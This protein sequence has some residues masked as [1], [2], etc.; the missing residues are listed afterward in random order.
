MTSE[1]RHAVQVAEWKVNEV[2]ELVERIKKSRVVGVVGLRELPASDIQRIRGVLRSQAEI[3][4]VRNNI[5]K[6]AIE[7]C[8][9]E[10]HPLA[11]GIEDQSALIFTDTNPFQLKKILDREKRPMLMKAGGVAPKEI[12]IEAGETSFSPGPMVGKLQSA[13]I[14][15]AI[16]GGKVIINQRTV[17]AKQGDVVSQKQ[18]EIMQIMEIFPKDVGLELRAVYEDGLVFREKDLA[19]DVSAILGDLC[20]ASARALAFAVEIG[21]A[22]PSTIAPLLTKAQAGAR[23][24]VVE[25]AIPVPGM[26]ELLLAKASANASAVASLVEGPKTRSKPAAAAVAEEPKEEEKKESEE[27]TAAG[28]GSL[29]G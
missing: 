29:F 24:L 19:I 14:P 18:A 12:A 4:V 3:K 27:D 15:A 23:N 26:A 11:E 9:P 22:S 20:T 17:L 16:K 5:A 28:L 13:G 25:A 10:I 2:K 1:A 6:R 21:Y 7:M 8:S